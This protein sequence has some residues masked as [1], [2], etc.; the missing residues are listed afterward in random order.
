M[1][2][3]RLFVSDAFAV[4]QDAFV[5]AVQTIE[6]ADPLAPLTVLVPTDCLVQHLLRVVSRTGHGHPGLHIF[7]LPE[8]A[9]EIAE[10][11]LAQ[12]GQQP[13]PPLTALW[14]AKKL[15]REAETNNYFAPLATQPG[16]PRDLLATITDLKQAEV[17]P[18]DLQRFADRAHLKG[19]YQHKI[20]SLSV[21]YARYARFLTEQRLYDDADL[22]ERAAVLRAAHSG[23]SPLILYGFSE[24]TSRQRRV[25]AAALRER[26]VLAFFPWRAGSAYEYATPA[27]AWLTSL[28]L[29]STP[30]FVRERPQT[31]LARVQA[32]LFEEGALR[33]APTRDRSVTLISTP[34][35]SR[36]AR[37]IGRAILEL[38]RE[39]D[40]RFDEIAVLLRDTMKGPLMAETLAGF[41]IPCVLSNGASLSQTQ[42]GQSLLLLCQMLAE[43]YA[44]PRVLEFL[45]NADPPFLTLLGELAAFARPAQWE[46]LSLEAG[47]V[48]GAEEWRERLSRLAADRRQRTV[49]D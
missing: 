4:L 47:I 33:S 18:H 24:F 14:I 19:T 32:R 48:R 28:G 46:A 31:D 36:E 37:E 15:L 35:E 17:R 49:D 8:F 7:T 16:F 22:L 41:G 10:R 39:Q 27:L 21:L 13:L 25:I 11:A 26:D 3:Q 20:E 45:K 9:R 30:L 1:P 23:T 5:T 38:V 42:A 44:R 43:D 34:N 6:T 40:L 29:R 12:E 2:Q